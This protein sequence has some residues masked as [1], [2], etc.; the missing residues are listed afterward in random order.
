MKIVDNKNNP[1]S[2]SK[3]RFEYYIDSGDDLSANML[4]DEYVEFRKLIIDN[5]SILI[6]E[7]KNDNP[8]IRN[9][10]RKGISYENA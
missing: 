4:W 2:M 3:V 7:M 8:L 5:P 1:V 6:T 10:C 9:H